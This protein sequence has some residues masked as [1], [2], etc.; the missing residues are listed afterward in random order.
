VLLHGIDTLSAA[1]RRAE[2]G[3]FERFARAGELMSYLGLVP[4][5]TRP[6]TNAGSARSPNPVSGTRGDC[7]RGGLALP[8]QTAPEPRAGQAPGRPARARD[9]HRLKGPAAPGQTWHRL[10]EEQGKRRTLVAVAVAR[11]LAGFV[12]AIAST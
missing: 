12:W 7:W 4:P 11:E 8:A 3:D 10:A 9:R 5:S 6:A 1:G 2:V